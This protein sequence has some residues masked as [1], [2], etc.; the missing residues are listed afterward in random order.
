MNH[1]S[2]RALRCGVATIALVASA[3]AYAQST[4]QKPDVGEVQ[5]GSDQ[6]NAAN[7]IRITDDVVVTGRCV[8]DSEIG[9]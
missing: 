7:G 4:D 1:V 3:S 8:A 5:P 6:T 9:T 2:L